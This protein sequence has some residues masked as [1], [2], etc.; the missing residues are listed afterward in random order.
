MGKW[1]DRWTGAWLAGWREGETDYG[2]TDG[3]R[4]QQEARHLGKVF[5]SV[6]E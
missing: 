2:W 4:G 6:A 1:M 5:E 3:G